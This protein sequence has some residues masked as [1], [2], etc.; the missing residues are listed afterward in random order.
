ML[1]ALPNTACAW[2]IKT[3]NVTDC[4]PVAN[5]IAGSVA[6]A[7][8]AIGTNVSVAVPVAEVCGI[9]LSFTVSVPCWSLSGSGRV[10]TMLGVGNGGITPVPIRVKAWPPI[11]RVPVDATA[12]VGLNCTSNAALAEGLTVL[13][14]G[15]WPISEKPLP[16]TDT[17]GTGSVAVV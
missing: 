2:P 14:A 1:L 6:F 12:A 15:G 8:D 9:A 17:L 11:V 7:I 3:L 4:P 16:L 5:A 10:S 13:P